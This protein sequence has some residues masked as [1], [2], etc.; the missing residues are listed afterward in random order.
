LAPEITTDPII[1][2]ENPKIFVKA[3][4]S[5]RFNYE[6]T[7]LTQELLQ[8]FRTMVNHAIRIALQEEIKGRFK[9]RNRIYKEFQEKYGVTSHYPYSVAE[10][11]WAIVKRHRRWGRSPTAK[12][13]VMKMEAQKYSLS[14]SILSLP[15]RK[16]ERIL[17]PLEYGDHQRAFLEGTAFKRGS[18]TMTDTVIAIAFSAQIPLGKPLDLMG[19]DLNEKSAV[20]S[21][22]IRYDLAEVARLHTEYGVRR[23][24]FNRRHPRDR[25]L[26]TKY[27]SASRERERVRQILHRAAKSVV[28]SAK[29]KGQVIVMENLRGIRNS[30]RKDRRESRGK[31]RRISHWPFRLFQDYVAY[32]AA[33]SGVNI[34]FVSAA[35]TSQTCN[36]CHFVNRKLKLTER[37]WRCP[38]CGAI[39][40][41]DLNAAVNIEK[42]GTIPCL[43]EVR[44][45][46]QGKDEA[47]KG[48]PTIPVILQAEALKLATSDTPF[49]ASGTARPDLGHMGRRRF[50]LPTSS[51]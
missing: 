43:G 4:K 26:C 7:R 23:S 29:A 35:W 13:L 30:H 27:A 51:V 1:G 34:E 9:L 2:S 11:A 3:V 12:R 22:G 19:L 31:R 18:I 25:R 50:G 44:P 40:D 8:T 10:I 38:S 45:G 42:R 49:Q 41:R 28:E 39:L 48:N 33:W 37:E 16:G 21:D 5:V 17:I 15:F 20:C 36:K 46:A 32:K 14:Y 24:E 6:P 47:M